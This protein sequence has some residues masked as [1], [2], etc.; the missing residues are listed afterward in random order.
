[1][2]LYIRL[3]FLVF[4]LVATLIVGTYFLTENLEQ[5]PGSYE[6]GGLIFIFFSFG[7]C[8]IIYVIVAIISLVLFFKKIKYHNIIQ[9]C[10][11]VLSSF[12]IFKASY[13]ICVENTRQQTP[14]EEALYA[15]KRKQQLQ[16]QYKEI[17]SLLAKAK[18][19]RPKKSQFIVDSTSFLD[20]FKKTI[21][22]PH[23]EMDS[24][25]RLVTGKLLENYYEYILDDKNSEA[26]N[27]SSAQIC[28][29]FKIRNIFYSPS[30]DIVVVIVS[31][32]TA[33]YDPNLSQGRR[34][35]SNIY[36]GHRV[37]DLISF[38]K[39]QYTRSKSNDDL[40]YAN[41]FEDIISKGYRKDLYPSMLSEKFWY[42]EKMTKKYKLKNK[43]YF[44]FEGSISSRKVEFHKNDPIFVLNLSD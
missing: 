37:G 4:N 14:E 11:F 2:K 42:L 9:I 36:I 19:F 6:M 12:L 3:I 5:V 31:Y 20:F 18:I 8:L 39:Y 44:Q 35:I 40:A 13:Q 15:I 32:E 21:C 34:G 27:T 38:Y 43:E 41:V 26:I 24:I 29:T 10:L 33:K 22:I 7:V 30:Y 28:K 1:M 23:E 25:H 16:D 17:P